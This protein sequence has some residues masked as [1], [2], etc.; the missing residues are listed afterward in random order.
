MST[1]NGP[2]IVWLHG[3]SL[4]PTDAALS[5]H[6][7]AP[8]LFVFDR[9]F[10]SSHAIAF[11]RLAFM[12]GGVRDVAAARPGLTEL[13]VGSVSAELAAFATEHGAAELHVTE[14]PTPEFGSILSGVRERCPGLRV[15][16][17]PAERLSSYSGQ[18]NKFFGF[19]NKVQSEVLGGGELFR[20]QDAPRPQ[21]ES[22]RRP[23][24]HRSDRNRRR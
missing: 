11:T 15:V 5:A 18:V 6:P 4:S 8:A 1:A 19:W 10:L 23:R 22:E 13:R 3:D 20:D 14:N 9:P 7:Q 24:D 2:V 17:Y 12:Y 21:P 16:I